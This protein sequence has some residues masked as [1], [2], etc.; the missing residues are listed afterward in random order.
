MAKQGEGEK[1]RKERTL[2]RANKTV[3]FTAAQIILALTWKVI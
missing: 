3:G 1:E 2:Q